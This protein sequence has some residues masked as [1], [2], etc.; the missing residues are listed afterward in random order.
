MRWQVLCGEGRAL[1]LAERV[2]EEVGSLPRLDAATIGR[3]AAGVVRDPR[4]WRDW[5]APAQ[6]LVHLKDLWLL[7]VAHG[8]PVAGA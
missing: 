6:I 3:A 1:R 7:L 2:V 4:R 5:G 8:A